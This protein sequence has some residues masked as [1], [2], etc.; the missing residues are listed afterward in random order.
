MTR[1]VETVAEGGVLSYSTHRY[2]TVHTWVGL[3][4][5]EDIYTGGERRREGQHKTGGNGTK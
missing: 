3:K 4:H 1:V 5:R 2:L